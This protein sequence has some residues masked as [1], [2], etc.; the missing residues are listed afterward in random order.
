MIRTA[1]TACAIVAWLTLAGP[2]TAQDTLVGL[3]EVR[4]YTGVI[5]DTTAERYDILVDASRPEDP[6]AG[7]YRTIQAAYAAAQAGT[8]QRQTVIGIRPDV[9]QLRGTETEP[10]LVITK[11]YIT[12]MGLT[13]D[14]RD[15]VLAD[16]R[17]NRQGAANNGFSMIVDADG[18]SAVNL[19]I[20]NACN[21]DYDYPGDPSKSLKKRSDVIT[22]AV[23]IQMSG[24]RH[25]YSH[26]AFLSRLDTMFNRTKRSYFTH[27]Y[28]EGTDDYLGAPGRS[29][30]EDSEI[31]FIEGGGILFAGATTFIRTRFRATRPMQ[32]YKVPVAPVSLIESILPDGPVAW[33]GWRAPEHVG[34]PS[35]TY[36]TVTAS[37]R[38]A[39][40]VDS[41]VGEPRRTISRELTDQERQALN[42]WNLLRFTVDGVDDGWDPAG[43]RAR[44]EGLGVQ[45]FRVVLDNATPRIRTGEEPAEIAARA[46]PPGSGAIRWTSGSPLA[47]LSASEGERV[48]VTAANTTERTAL[49]PI[50][51]TAAN[52]LSSTAFVTVEPAYR[53]A[54][55]LRGQPVITAW[56]GML[57]LSY[58]LALTP[59]RTDQ[60]LITWFA[61][62]DADCARPER[63]AVS[64]GEAPLSQLA[65]SPRLA[66]RP[67]MA[68]IEPRHDLSLP[69]P[70]RRAP[71][72]TAPS[73]APGAAGTTRLQP[74]SL[75]DSPA[76]DRW[77]GDWTLTGSWSAEPPLEEGGRWGLRVGG[78]DSTLLH[79]GDPIAGDMDVTVE[80]DTDKLEGQGFSIP[81]SPEDAG[82]PRADILFKYDP[83]TRT[84]YA[85]RFWRT[86]R[87]ATAVAFQLYRITNG[88]GT[89]M[90]DP[91]LTGVVKPT[92]T[93]RIS[94]RGERVTA[95]GSNTADG[96]VLNL[97]G[98]IEPNRFGGAGLYW[99]ASR[100]SGSVVLRG[101]TVSYLGAAAPH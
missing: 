28:L 9:Y 58:D 78:E 89:P 46:L 82:R 65:V 31:N 33:F 6:A 3:G 73:A 23:A 63:I 97:T 52:G 20:L 25:V 2:A 29:V 68:T 83:A 51:A 37:G 7:R 12:L 35:L 22:Q 42:P 43:V 71:V 79:V 27:S 44:H 11:P 67:V 21:L 49:V 87:S 40:I 57:R 74:R 59:G 16:N 17:G 61:C 76:S 24:D 30:W 53:P 91:Q 55:D 50:E 62:D 95:T 15:V 101:L 36:R 99:T 94:V 19:T 41:S 34:E 85:L 69:G 80:L 70:A 18:F 100:F 98:R 77:E 39:D 66:G 1:M 26:V 5:F 93:L 92:T 81:G 45:P 32:F 48:R 86:T 72:V 88:E 54:P 84:G 14:R 8:V 75:P 96:Q 56:E 90:G 60:S 4:G 64:R 38:P 13:R 10:G 47:R